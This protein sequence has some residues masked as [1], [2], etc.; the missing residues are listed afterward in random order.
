MPLPPT[1]V[2]LLHGFDGGI[3]QEADAALQLARLIF[4]TIVEGLP[5]AIDDRGD[6]W[7]ISSINHDHHGTNCL[8]I[9]KL[10]AAV[11]AVEGEHSL[12]AL[13][14]A[15][16]VEKFT[17]ILVKSNYGDGELERQL[18]FTI[19]DKGKAWEVLGYG[20]ANRSG[21]GS[22]RFHLEVQKHDAQVL[23]MSFQWVFPYPQ[24]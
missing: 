20:D 18:P 13:P 21:D 23:D 17:T 2:M 22:G 16:T 12:H 7:L 19:V 5:P 14:T 9:R 3:V 4:P 6:Q 10:D 24:K 1:V 11:L 15:K 8:T